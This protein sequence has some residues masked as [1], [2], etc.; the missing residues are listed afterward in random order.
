[1][2]RV[3]FILILFIFA[4]DDED[5]NEIMGC[6]EEVAC[7]FDE[8]ATIDDGSCEYPEENFNCDGDCIAEFDCNDECG[9]DAQFDD[10][11]DCDGGNSCY[12]CTNPSAINYDSNATVDDDSC[13]HDFTTIKVTNEFGDILGIIGEGDFTGGCYSE[14][15]FQRSND[16]ETPLGNKIDSPYPN[17]GKSISFNITIAEE[18]H[19]RLFIINQTNEIIHMLYDD[20]IDPVLD[21]TFTWNSVEGSEDIYDYYRVIADFEDGECFHNITNNRYLIGCMD[22]TACNYNPSALINSYQCAYEFDECGVCGGDGP[23]EGY[24]CDWNCI[25]DNI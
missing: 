14:D 3:L 17:P 8:D 15:Y 11:G 9:G 16:G 13:E 18:Q 10:C 6:D 4:C 12:G 25:I 2:I 24:D 22:E 21:Y 5:E 7:N 19:F 20:I 23:E 1:M